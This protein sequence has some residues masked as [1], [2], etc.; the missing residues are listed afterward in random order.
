MNLLQF[1]EP[2]FIWDPRI[3]RI[4]IQCEELGYASAYTFKIFLHSKHKLFWQATQEY[5]ADMHPIDLV[6]TF[7]S[8]V[9]KGID[10]VY[11]KMDEQYGGSVD[12]YGQPLMKHVTDFW[13]LDQQ[14]EPIIKYAKVSPKEQFDVWCDQIGQKFS[15][16]NPNVSPWQS[17]YYLDEDAFDFNNYALKLANEKYSK[18]MYG[19]QL[20]YDKTYSFT[21]FHDIGSVVQENLFR[22]IPGLK[23]K[24]SCPNCGRQN[25][26]SE[27]I[28]HLND[29][30][31][32]S[33]TAIADWIESLDI[34]TEVKEV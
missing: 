24:A 16:F 34:N 26:L 7:K 18:S 29:A 11:A 17:A 5:L 20:P 1:T 15:R 19:Q 22:L 13:S 33:R 4:D 2:I 32:W 8:S 9:Q 12:V 21:G 28:I 10:S 30:H 14:N 27:L 3:K 25:T 31:Q 23:E 6:H